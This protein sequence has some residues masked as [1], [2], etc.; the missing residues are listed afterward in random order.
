MKFVKIKMYTHFNWFFLL[1]VMIL[2]AAPASAAQHRVTQLTPG[3]ATSFSDFGRVVNTAG[4]VNND[5]FSDIIVSQPNSRTLYV[6][7][8]SASGQFTPASGSV[9]TP[10]W[11]DTVS[12]GNFGRALA[13]GDFNCDGIDDV[14]VGAY[15]GG[16][17]NEGQVYVYYGSDVTGLSGSPDWRAESDTNFAWFGW[18]V[19]S[20]GDINQDGCNDLLVGGRRSGRGIAAL[21][22]GN[23]AGLPDADSDGVA[24][25]GD[26]SWSVTSTSGDLGQA[27]AG[28]GDVNND[29]VDDIL[30]GSRNGN[31]YLYYGVA[32][33]V[34][35]TSADWS[36][37][38]GGTFGR[39]VARAG[40][41]NGDTIADFIIGQSAGNGGRV[42]LYYGATGG[43]RTDSNPDW[44]YTVPSEGHSHG[45]DSGFASTISRAGDING[46]GYDDFMVGWPVYHGGLT[47]HLGRLYI[48]HGS[49]SGPAI[50]PDEVVDG[51]Q[52]GAQFATSVS[53]AGDVDGDLLDDFVVGAPSH[54]IAL[55]G[56]ISGTGT[57]FAYLSGSSPAHITIDPPQSYSN[58]HV[59][60][61]DGTSKTSSFS[62]VL[63]TLPSAEV[64]VNI[65]SNNSAEGVVSPAVLTF[66]TGD[67]N[68]P[69]TVNIAGIDDPLDDGDIQYTISI[70]I[71]S[72]G[73]EYSSV[74]VDDVNV[75]NQDD[76]AVGIII[77]PKSDLITTEDLG[78]DTFT[79]V[80]DA[81]PTDN[82]TIGLS[83]SDPGEGSVFPAAVTFTPVNFRTPQQVTITGVDDTILDGNIL[84]TI[85]TAPAMSVDNRYNNL[86]AVDLAVTNHDN[87]LQTSLNILEGDQLGSLFG[88]TVSRAGD[89]NGDGFA[90]FIVG[91]PKHDNGQ[92]NEGRVYVYFG[93]P[94]GFSATPWSAEYDQVSAEFGWSVASAGDV[95]GD[96]F[97]DIIIGARKYDGGETDEG[98]VFVYYGSAT[99]LPAT[100]DWM[101]EIDQANANFGAA[102]SG[103]GDVNGDGFDDILVG[104][105]NYYAADF[106][107][108]GASQ[109]IKEGAAFLFYGSATGLSD[110]IPDGIAHL[111][112]GDVAWQG[113]TGGSN[114][115]SSAKYGRTLSRAGD[116]NCDG[117]AD[118]IVGAPQYNLTSF[119]A[120][121]WGRVWVYYGSSG[122][123][124]S[125]GNADW[126]MLGVQSSTSFGSSVGG[127]G[128]ING[129]MNGNYSCDDIIIGA[130][131]YESTLFPVSENNEGQIYVYYGSPTGLVNSPSWTHE[132]NQANSKLGI[133]SAI[134]GD[135]NNDGFADI[136]AGSNRY[137]SG[138]TDEGRVYIYFG[139]A[140]GPGNPLTREINQPSAYFGTAVDGVGDVDGDGNDDFIVGAT[141]YDG[142]LFNEGAAFL[143]LSDE[144]AIKVHPGSGLVTTETGGSDSFSV[145]LTDAPSANVTIALSSDLTE[146]TLSSTSLLFTPVNWFVSQSVTVT[147][148]D[149]SDVDGNFPYAVVTAAAVSADNRYSGLNA[150]DVAVINLDNEQPT[151]GITATDNAA[152]ETGS[153]TGT[154]TVSRTGGSPSPLQVFYTLS[155]TATNGLDYQNLA[156]SVTIA[157]G[158]SN[159][160]ITLIPLLDGFF[161]PNETVILTLSADL[162]YTV[163]TANASAN[164]SDGT[165]NGI[166]ISPTSGL[167]TTEQGGN[168]TFSVVLN[169]L[170]TAD[171]TINFS[172]DTPSEGHPLVDSVIFTTVDWDTPQTVT[173]VGQDDTLVD[174]DVLYNIVTSVTSGDSSYNVLNPDDVA[175]T[176]RDD[177]NLPVVNIVTRTDGVNEGG[178]ATFRV[179]RTGSTAANL[180]V[181]YSV[182]GGT[183]TNGIDYLTP[184]G[185]VTIFGGQSYRDLNV[186]TVNDIDPEGDETV[187]LSLNDDTTYIVSSP[188]ADTAIIRGDPV[189]FPVNFG[190]DQIVAEGATIRV[191][192]IKNNGDYNTTVTYTVSGSA[193][194]PTDH[195]AADGSIVLAWSE[196]Q[197]YIT[198]N[199]IA[200]GL[201]ESDETVIF[202]LQ[203]LS[204]TGQGVPG[205][206]IIHKVTITESNLQPVINLAAMQSGQQTHLVVAGN[207]KVTLTASVTDP[208]PEDSHSYDWSL[209]NNNL[210][211]D[212][213][214]GDPA[215]FVFDPSG[216]TPGVYKARVTVTDN[217]APVLA[218][219]NELLFEVVATEPV[220]G[221]TD[222]D[223]DFSN[224]KTESYDD[225]DNDGIP[226]YL[227]PNYIFSQPDRNLPLD[228]L[229]QLPA[230]FRSYVMR[231]DPGLALRLGDIAFAAGSDAAQVSVADIANF[232]DG[233]GGAGSATAQDIIPNIGGYFDFEIANLPV[234]GTSA[235]VVIPQFE[236]LPSGARYRK[237][238]PVNGWNDFV[239]NAGN[240]LASAPGIPGICPLPGDTAYIPGLTPGHFC[241]QLT[242]EDGGPNDTDGVANHVIEDPGQIG[243]VESVEAVVQGDVDHDEP[244]AANNL[245]G[246]AGNPVQVNEDKP[247]ILNESQGGGVVNLTIILGLFFV[248]LINLWRRRNDEM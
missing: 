86:N 54:S 209:S 53:T 26:Y 67:W 194:N 212:N 107:S 106:V 138:E 37:M 221:F 118:I 160:A 153:N 11:Q 228:A 28:I 2:V 213:L 10:D 226:D 40:K 60:S 197:G 147:G 220:L 199:T 9:G 113:E 126:T 70:T 149:D 189:S 247:S 45:S 119:T 210:V 48:F 165:A 84:Y 243:T 146:G 150:D 73:S 242:I 238:H 65:T 12:A 47:G 190:P 22:F 121:L 158:N 187:I 192:V 159:A 4:D 161:E 171:V 59:T 191:P 14:A 128:N 131:S 30:V 29:T 17:A 214:D 234:A 81:Q 18:S 196:T 95:N 148:V 151:V 166:T 3:L 206:K 77:E 32:S 35:N 100:P 169:S 204:P 13:A 114:A 68:V 136:I 64:T 244:P 155:G 141:L 39:A 122:G 143:Y 225:S 82:V 230:H 222:S 139:S 71:V 56:T 19:S 186:N 62:V 66:T 123:L 33:G 130:D 246:N 172:S 79:I 168:D 94:T 7:Y 183:A 219:A 87:N 1:T 88:R 91:A 74:T 116:V 38:G 203:T 25:P 104:A 124:R 241:V 163:G 201:S 137:D 49:A 240:V 51:I 46:D 108:S 102:V 105:D 180:T 85:I 127:A 233:E 179:S 140:T 231:T 120:G 224:D 156:G 216:L 134:A 132:N 63:D 24:H 164:I 42:H 115:I 78:T 117:F 99:G 80:L 178:F 175:V 27:V 211:D 144:A 90:D 31:V 36:D 217:G 232:G 111:S 20:A 208:N 41:V 170:P 112:D 193:M 135:L 227:D 185:S 167:M 145:V 98:R 235:N 188:R 97:D 125:D 5:G 43:P 174:G 218:V 195:N 248:T 61:E 173:V 184:S 129:D 44:S 92:T 157:A 245:D 142:D 177:D 21:F 207:G 154:F 75:T 8:G 52:E 215:T 181:N 101:A 236:A 34:P 152:S 237:Y 76:D 93:A 109:F 23:S 223:G 200:D 6:Y 72:S 103:A 176:N 205:N 16:T 229:Q 89:I 162:A 96:R 182:I 198:F 202:T 55:G 50:N 83:S 239:E 15:S 57:A 110:A 69:Q 133:S 58:F